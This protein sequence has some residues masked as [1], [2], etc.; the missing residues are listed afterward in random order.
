MKNEI[1]V[2]FTGGTI[3]SRTTD[4]AIDVHPDAGYE[5]LQRYSREHG[6]PAS[7]TVAQPYAILSE[8]M[9]PGDWELLCRTI[10]RYDLSRFAGVIIT[11]GTDTLAYTAAAISYR[12]NRTP[13]PILLTASNYP[14]DHPRTEALRNFAAC[15]EMIEND[16]P[17][18]IY[19]VFEDDLRGML[20]HLGTRVRQSEPFTDRFA[21][22]YDEP[23]G[24]IENGKLIIHPSRIH[25]SAGHLRAWYERPIIDG[26]V[27]FT[28]DI[29]FVKPYPGFRYTHL[30]ISDRRPD[31]VLI[32]LYHSGT[33]GLR[34]ADA[35][36]SLE[37]FAASCRS[38]GIP[39][40][41]APMKTKTDGLYATSHDLLSYGVIPLPNM[42]VEAALVKLML[43][44]G[45]LTDRREIEQL[46]A[47][48][49]FYEIAEV[50]DQGDR[51]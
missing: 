20:V 8:N 1:L 10:E 13:V 15:V 12:F 37:S 51:R 17:P 45:S 46:L 34:F 30:Q 11:H 7:F 14:L 43:A 44:Y 42:S 48:N 9:L 49:L 27:R 4:D 18:G 19:V 39:I 24:A 36:D 16:P 2:I 28:G 26:N 50:S 41:I 21:S 31:A 25:P 35:D 33:T 22:I 5:L 40:Y 3:G 6:K 23:F 32:E 38:A 29:L 47:T